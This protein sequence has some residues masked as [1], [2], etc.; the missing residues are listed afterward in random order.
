M[1][2]ERFKS[3]LRQWTPL[4]GARYARKVAE[5]NSRVRPIAGW[6]LAIMTIGIIMVLSSPHPVSPAYLI[7]A[8]TMTCMPH[9]G[10]YWCTRKYQLLGKELTVELQSA[11]VHFKDNGLTF[12]WQSAYK[13]WAT[14]NGVQYTTVAAVTNQHDQNNSPR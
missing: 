1:A 4:V 11:G 9:L 6:G 7:P 10:F 8:V 5:L 14:R 2:N 13:A 3:D 12:Q